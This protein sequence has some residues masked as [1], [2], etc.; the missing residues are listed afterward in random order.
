MF[1]LT[2]F[3]LL[4][5]TL[6]FTFAALPAHK[7]RG[8][9]LGS[10]FIVE[11]WM[12]SGT[13]KDMGCGDAASEW[14]CVAALGQDKANAAFQKHWDTFITADDFERMREYGLN[15]VRIPVGHWFVEETIAPGENWP[16]GGMK[17]LDKVAG[18]AASKNISVIL[19]LHG[20]PGVQVPNNAFTGHTL[21]GADFYSPPNYD[22][23][24]IFLRNMTERVHTHASYASTF[25]LEVLNEPEHNH[26]SLIT[27]YYPKAYSTIRDVERD[28][29]IPNSK[30]L[31]VQ[32]MDSTWGAGNPRQNLPKDASGLAFDNHRYLTYSST[33]ATKADYLKASCAD[34][35]AS[36][37]N[38]KPLVIGEWSLAIKQDSEWS[39]E[40][41]PIKQENHDWYRQWW[42]AQVQAYEKQ[43]G[44]VMW[45]W[46][47]ELGGDWRWSYSA[48]VEAGIIPK[49]QFGKAKAMAK[50]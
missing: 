17:Y 26:D 27:D 34:A 46:K 40:F 4:T 24:Y 1:K 49:K 7:I 42:A 36:Q 45:S 22:R 6:S 13:W 18:L 43:K 3:A 35:F 16:R 10:L 12:S 38:N 28:L 9:N 8:V 41:S 15:T 47:T 31:T 39:D 11:P 29:K 23:A 14:D 5:T 48:A 32:M 37:D 19:D 20:A 50:C 33:P 25:M 21:P 2:L 44:W 30:R